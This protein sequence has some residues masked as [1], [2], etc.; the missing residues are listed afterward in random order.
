MCQ[1]VGGNRSKRRTELRPIFARCDR[2]VA[3]ENVFFGERA[4]AAE[5][6]AAFP[7]MDPDGMDARV[8]SQEFY[9][10]VITH[11]ELLVV[12]E[13]VRRY[14]RR[15]RAPKRVLAPL[16]RDSSDERQS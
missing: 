5:L 9:E 2:D 13:D 7:V 15:A 3:F 10:D 12:V 14:Y 8:A 1:R 16:H 4:A 11:V 6:R